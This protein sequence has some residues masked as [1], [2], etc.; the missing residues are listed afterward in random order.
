MRPVILVLL[1]GCTL[2][3]AGCVRTIA[4]STVGGIVDEGFTA[5]TEETDL[6]FAEQALPAN[7]KLLEVM[8]KNDPTNE[9]LLRLASEAYCSYALAFLE[10]TDKRRAR[11]FYERG[12]DYAFRILRQE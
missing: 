8:L 4:V 1:V 10:D 9:R 3:L 5:F 12:R 2:P 6:A 7:M 11:D